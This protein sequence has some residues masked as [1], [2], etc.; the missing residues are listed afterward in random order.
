[1]ETKQVNFNKG[2]KGEKFVADKI[3]LL[4][5]H[6]IHIG[7]ATKFSIDGGKFFSGDLLV[8]GK[9]K[10]FITQV[11]YKEPRKMYPDTGLERARFDN[12]KWLQKETGSEVL[13][14]FTD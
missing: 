14:L 5:Y 13:L 3:N 12:L 11:K 7:G 8:F 4:G 1:M 9:G 10:M 6:V 2:F